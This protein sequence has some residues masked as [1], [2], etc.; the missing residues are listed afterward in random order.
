[1]V[2]RP[3]LAWAVLALS[4]TTGVCGSSQR[5][6]ALHPRALSH[7]SDIAVHIIPR[8]HPE[9]HLAPRSIDL[10]PAWDDSFLLSF[11]SHDTPVTLSLRPSHTLLHPGGIKSVH[12]HTDENGVRTTETRVMERKEVRAYEGWVLEEGADLDQWIREEAAGVVR[13]T[14]LTGWARV[15]LV[16][17]E[18]DDDELAFQGSFADG[19]DIFTI[20]STP[21]Y[22]SS[23][24][25][26]DPDPPLLRK[27]GVYAHPSM[28]I[29]RERDTLSPSEQVAALR[30]RGF[31]VPAIPTD[32]SSLSDQA[33]AIGCGHDDL[34]FNIDPSHPVYEQ[35]LL[36]QTTTPWAATLFGLPSRNP[37]FEPR[38]LSQSLETYAY[39]PRMRKRQQGDIGGSSGMTSN[40]AGSIG[41][42]S[43]CPKQAMVVFVGVA[44]D[45]TY[46]AS[47]SLLPSSFRTPLLT[48]L[49]WLQTMDPPTSH[50]PRSSP[51]STRLPPSTP[52]RSTSPSASSS[53][54]S[55]PVPARLRPRK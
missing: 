29:V 11:S 4:L 30:K 52:P 33:T 55:N 20:H 37:P 42:T 50:A 22:L 47:T 51:S 1:M 28:V 54:T 17:S 25:S 9:P 3:S 8:G 7:P 26:L 36:A 5:P 43:G 40:F 14:S 44:A 6:A 48:P 12:T 16:P 15:V 34:S 53:S 38:D 24:E 23:R 27:R 39:P 13:D 10:Q 21:T 18:S 19:N 41:S 49:S 35:S 2:P 45:C 46:V 31:A 32:G